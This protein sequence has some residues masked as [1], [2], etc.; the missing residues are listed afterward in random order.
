MKKT[1]FLL[2]SIALLP[3]SCSKDDPAP[4]LTIGATQYRVAAQQGSRTNAAFET[5][6]SWSATVVPPAAGTQPWLSV[7]PAS[8]QAGKATLVLTASAANPSG[9]ERTAYVDIAYGEM[10]RRLTVVQDALGEITIETTEYRLSSE[11][12]SSVTARIEVGIEWQANVVPPAAGTQPWL[13]VSPA[14][15]QAGSS[16]LTLSA[17]QANPS[18]NERTAYVDIAYGE[19]SRRLTVVQEGVNIA[20]AF[21]PLFAQELQKRGYIPD[22]TRITPEQVKDIVVLDVSGT[23][24]QPG[25]LT[26]LRGI[27]YFESLKELECGKNQLTSLDVSHNTALTY[28]NCSINRLT[29]LDVSQNAVLTNLQYDSNQLTSLDVSHNAALKYLFG[30]NNLLTSLDVSQNT[31]LKGLR[32]ANN[33]LA[34]LDVSQNTALEHLESGFNQLTSLDVSQNTAL[35]G[36]SCYSNRLTSLDVSHNTILV[37]L[38]CYSNQLPSLDVSKNTALTYLSC[39][40]NPGDGVSKFPVTAWFDNSAVPSSDFT[41]GGWIYSG[42]SIAVDYRKAD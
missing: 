30:N 16:I 4:E 37:A 21:D 27:E 2:L 25:S 26:S 1:L 15:G 5:N 8:G 14:S 36:L 13:S 3:V 28:L 18:G 29:S 12:N 19:M 33:Q 39:N 20:D 24:E 42:K 38:D 22:A 11:K 6:T 23:S 32:C 17:T 35:N 31:A 41:T 7:S 9:N 34:T 40:D 10:S